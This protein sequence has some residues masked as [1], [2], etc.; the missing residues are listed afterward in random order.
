[1]SHFLARSQSC[2]EH[3]L[4]STSTSLINSTLTISGT[5][6]IR[7]YNQELEALKSFIKSIGKHRTYIDTAFDL[8]GNNQQKSNSKVVKKE[9]KSF[10]MVTALVTLFGVGILAAIGFW[11]YKKKHSK[12]LPKIKENLP[13][14]IPNVYYVPGFGQIPQHM[15]PNDHCHQ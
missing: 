7:I 10:T 13:P 11:Y 15:V 9:S 14:A 6:Y 1:M 3:L 5:N 12:S 8:D 4:A 2:I